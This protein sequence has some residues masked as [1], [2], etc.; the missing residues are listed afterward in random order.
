MTKFLA[1]LFIMI[2]LL[3]FSCIASPD[4]VIKIA[5]FDNPK[6]VPQ[7]NWLSQELQNAYISGI[8]TAVYAARLQGIKIHYQTFLFESGPLSMLS[9]VSAVNAWQPDAIVGLHTSDQLLMSRNYFKNIM[10][11]S[12]FA[13]DPAVAKLP[14][15]F[16]SLEIPDPHYLNALINF[17]GDKFPGGNL[18]ILFQ[19]DSKENTDLTKALKTR[20]TTKFP[21]LT[22]TTA[23]FLGLHANN[24]DVK[25]FFKNYHKGD[26]IVIFSVSYFDV[27]HL[28]GGI[29]K[30]LAQENPVFITTVAY[31]GDGVMVS[32]VN[33]PY[34]GYRLRSLLPDPHSAAYAKFVNYYT[35]TTGSPPTQN[36]SYI[37]YNAIMSIVDAYTSFPSSTKLSMREQILTS[38]Q[39][40]L[41]SNKN[42]YRPTVFVVYKMTPNAESLFET[43]GVSNTD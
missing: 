32:D 35:S 19:S 20:Y 41:K 22:V 6:I 7:D 30:Y 27:T 18:F 31:R 34:V 21:K 42:W 39:N 40:A 4:P 26:I 5:I 43:L 16:Y 24:L 23:S 3:L 9:Q 10:V 37:T 15:N 28:M 33:T 13:N 17:I 36:I 11:L 1:N 2:M 25:P 38:Y 12:L 14:N 8:D 29:S